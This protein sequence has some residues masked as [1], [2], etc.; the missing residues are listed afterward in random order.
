MPGP[1]GSFQLAKSAVLQLHGQPLQLFLVLGQI[2][3]LQL[4]RFIPK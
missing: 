2:Q 4:D 1:R 3:Q